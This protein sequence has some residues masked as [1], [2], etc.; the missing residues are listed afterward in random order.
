MKLR[1]PAIPLI[2]ND[3]YFSIWSMEDILAENDTKHWTGKSHRIM[4]YLEIDGQRTLFMGNLPNIPAMKQQSVDIDALSTYYVY[5]CSAVT[6]KVTFMSPLLMDDLLLLSRPV[7]YIKTEVQSADGQPHTVTVTFQFDDEICLTQ[8]GE[9]DTV[10]ELVEWGNIRGAKLGN[11][12]QKILN[13]SG[14]DIRIDWGYFYAVT[15]EEDVKVSV[16]ESI[17]ENGTKAN[18]M[19][20]SVLLNTQ[21]HNSALF[22]VAYDDLKAIE[23]FGEPLDA[24]WKSNGDTIRN[25]L[26]KAIDEYPVLFER[27]CAFSR[28]MQTE[29]VAAGSEKYAELLALSYRQSIAAH[30]LCIDKNG[31]VLFISKEC[32]SNGCAATVD[33]SYPSI[34]LFLLYNP[35]LVAGMLRPI[36]RYAES[37]V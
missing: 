34:P 11:R 18:T 20:L 24:Y 7:S 25:V 37:S 23:Y 17:N 27:C 33:V 2:I 16:L 13:A 21:S 5:G 28:Q 4:G 6:L 35:E 22:A 14:D 31:E 26:V 9:S 15:D 32:F 1:A 12:V 10:F 3:P 8:K 19:E 36:Y 30:K 29:A